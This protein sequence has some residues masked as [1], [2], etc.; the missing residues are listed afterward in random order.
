MKYEKERRQRRKTEG[1][2]VQERRV[3]SK[4]FSQVVERDKTKYVRKPRYVWRSIDDSLL[5]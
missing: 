2:R 1:Q 4:E 3:R 5:E